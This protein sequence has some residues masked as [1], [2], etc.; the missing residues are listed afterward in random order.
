M[1]GGRS[2]NAANV[3]PL[4]LRAK[5]IAVFEIRVGI[6]I[7]F[8]E[9]DAGA[10]GHRMRPFDIEGDFR[11]PPVLLVGYVVRLPVWLDLMK[12]GG[13]ARPN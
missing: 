11:P 6:G 7:A 13:S 2:G 10:G 3:V 1:T 4:M 8:H 5:S 12:M 9:H